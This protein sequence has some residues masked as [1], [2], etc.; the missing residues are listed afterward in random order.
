MNIVDRSTVSWDIGHH[1][2][3]QDHTS[4]IIHG[5]KWYWSGSCF[6]QDLKNCNSRHASTWLKRKKSYIYIYIPPLIRIHASKSVT[7]TL[8]NIIKWI[9]LQ[10]T[11]FK[12]EQMQCKALEVSFWNK[13]TI[14]WLS[15]CKERAIEERSWLRQS[16]RLL[17]EDLPTCYGKQK[18]HPPMD[19][20]LWIELSLF[21]LTFLCIIFFF[22]FTFSNFVIAGM[23]SGM[24][25][26]RTKWIEAR[27]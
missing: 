24:R 4:S 25:C 23:N 21:S 7:S 16:C 1:D 22:F 10:G 13:I 19:K 14:Y 20:R 6:F 18:T 9:V 15:G 26:L 12:R 3:D 2:Y 27:V 11:N 8:I 5:I 17:G